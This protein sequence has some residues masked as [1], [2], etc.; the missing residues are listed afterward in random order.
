MKSFLICLLT[1]IATFGCIVSIN[2][3]TVSTSDEP[4]QS[5]VGQKLYG[6]QGVKASSTGIP[7]APIYLSRDLELT[8]SKITVARDT[9]P[10]LSTLTVTLSFAN[11]GQAILSGQIDDYYLTKAHSIGI[12]TLAAVLNKPLNPLNA[13]LRVTPVGEIDKGSSYDDML[14]A[15]GR[16]KQENTY[17]DTTQYVYEGANYYVNNDSGLITDIQTFTKNPDIE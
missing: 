7:P 17:G 15:L 10:N 6:C 11:L 5:L 4:L 2:A 3:Q 12:G 16:P 13:G 8:V 1:C 14:C 9:S